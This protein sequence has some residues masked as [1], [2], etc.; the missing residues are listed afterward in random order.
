MS[1]M[2]HGLRSHDT[3]AFKYQMAV[4]PLTILNLLTQVGLLQGEDIDMT[5]K[6]MILT[7][8]T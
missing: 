6:I 1:A 3:S 5:C 4:G 8:N 2:T 7:F